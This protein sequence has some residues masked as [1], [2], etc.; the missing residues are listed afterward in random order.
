MRLRKSLLVVAAA[1]LP[2]AS[3]ALLDGTASAKAVVGTGNPTCSFGGSLNFNPPLS[4]TAAKK[5]TKETTT[6]SATLG[7]CTGGNPA[8][9]GSTVTVKPIKS[10]TQKGQ[11]SC[12]AFS[13]AATGVKVKVKIA[14]NGE[15]PSKFTIVGLNVAVNPG[16]GPGTGELGFTGSGFPISGSYAGSGSL[17]VYLTQ[18]SSNAIATCGGG[19]GVSSLQIDQSQSSGTL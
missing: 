2:L 15:K 11:T 19:A 9:S 7:S 4:N 5:T 1:A 16:P 17:T 8:P 13:S 6:V 12:G 10:K 18:A 14:W 3:V